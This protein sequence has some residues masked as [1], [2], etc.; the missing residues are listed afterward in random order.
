MGCDLIMIM[1]GLKKNH[2]TV[3]SGGHPNSPTLHHVVISSSARLR[4]E[5]LLPIFSLGATQYNIFGTSNKK[6]GDEETHN[7]RDGQTDTKIHRQTET[8]TER[9][10]EVHIEVVPT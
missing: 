3:A 6:G 2:N 5:E 9:H 7:F 4:I 8:Q 10:T 1:E